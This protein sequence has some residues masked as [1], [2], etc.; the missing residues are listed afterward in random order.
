LH[1][2]ETNNEKEYD[3]LTITPA[4]QPVASIDLVCLGAVKKVTSA[5]VQFQFRFRALGAAGAVK[6]GDAVSWSFIQP[7]KNKEIAPETYL[8]LSQ[9]Q[10]FTPFCFLEKKVQT[11]QNTV[12]SLDEAGNWRMT[13]TDQTTV[14]V[15]GV[16]TDWQRFLNWTPI[17]ALERLKKQSPGPL[18][19]ETEL[20][21]EIV[22]RDYE[23]GGSE[24]G[25]E[26]GQTAYPVTSG[27]RTFHAIVGPPIEGKT[28]KK[29]LEDLR[30]LKKNRPPLFGLLH[31]ERC[32][33]VLQPLASF[34]TSPEYLTFSQEKVDKA[35]LLREL[36]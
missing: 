21:E 19:L 28:L 22:L 27:H 7:V 35:A 15:G 12:V 6:S 16:F 25:D 36:F 3:R 32:R 31:Y 10:K 14:T 17:G 29:H 24:E 23:V 34:T 1:A 20:Q 8:H 9:K 11:I 33:L 18:D 2:L 13:L 26:P 30:K 5:V 4:T